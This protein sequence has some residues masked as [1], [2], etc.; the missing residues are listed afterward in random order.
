[1]STWVIPSF[2]QCH[3]LESPR[4]RPKVMG[5]WL[6]TSLT[7]KYFLLDIETEV[8]KDYAVGVKPQSTPVES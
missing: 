5:L 2:Q 6:G 7:N 4:R 3:L 8:A 1:M